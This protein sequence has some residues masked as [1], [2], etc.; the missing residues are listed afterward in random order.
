MP[1]LVSICF[2]SE[3]KVN[4]RKSI[5]KYPILP[6]QTK[7]YNVHTMCLLDT[8]VSLKNL[9]CVRLLPKCLLRAYNVFKSFT[10]ERPLECLSLTVPLFVIKHPMLVNKVSPKNMVYTRLDMLSN[11]N[12]G[13]QAQLKQFCSF[14]SVWSIYKVLSTHSCSC[15]STSITISG[16]D[17]NEVSTCS[18]I[19]W[20]LVNWCNVLRFLI[21]SLVAM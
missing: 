8:K 16:I 1:Q 20:E 17:H 6:Y 13:N 15:T 19:F 18:K 10:N 5:Q 9:H 21:L 11:C 14:Y 4:F 2:Q 7:S 3:I 12:W